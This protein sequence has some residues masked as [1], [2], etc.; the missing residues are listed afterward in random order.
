MIDVIGQTV[1]DYVL[2]EYLGAG[3]VGQVF[4][5]R[6]ITT[7]R[8]H[9][10]K[11]VHQQLADD[12]DFRAW[13]AGRWR[14]VAR[15]RSRQVIAVDEVA[16]HDAAGRCYVVMELLDTSAADLLDPAPKAARQSLIGWV[17]LIGQAG[18]ALAIAQAAGLAHG[19]LKPSNLRLEPVYTAQSDASGYRL[20]LSDFGFSGV[21]AIQQS[22]GASR[23][24]VSEALAYTLAPEH[25]RGDEPDARSD[26]YA[27]GA[28]MYHA[29]TGRPPFSA[30]TFEAALRQRVY[31][32]LTP[33]N[34]LQ[35]ALPAELSAALEAALKLE[36]AGRF[37]DAQA[38]AAALRRALVLPEERAPVVQAL[39]LKGYALASARLSGNGL[40]VGRQPSTEP[41]LQL[42]AAVLADIE[43]WIDWD[44][45]QVSVTGGSANSVAAL[46]GARLQ[47]GQVYPWDAEE[48]LRVGPYILQFAQPADLAVAQPLVLPQISHPGAS[49]PVPA[50]A[51][52]DERIVVSLPRTRL[53]LVP[54]QL[55]V[56]A[57]SLKNVGTLVDNLDITVEGIPDQWIEGT[58]ATVDLN[59]NDERLS[60]IR[61]RV[62]AIPKNHAREYP[63]VIRVR[64]RPLGES[65]TQPA[66]WH[67]Q[68]F[69][70]STLD[71]RP[72]RRR[73][74]RWASYIV[75]LRNLGNQEATYQLSG[76]DEENLLDC[77]LDLLRVDARPG[78]MVEVPLTTRPLHR[79]WFGAA[80]RHRFT[81][82]A[83]PRGPGEPRSVTGTF[84]QLPVFPQWLP[85]ALL[86]LLIVGLL[87]A[88]LFGFAPTRVAQL[89][90]GKPGFGVLP[91]PTPSPLPSPTLTLPTLVPP[92]APAVPTETPLPT[93][94]QTATPAPTAT[95][96][97]TAT[98]TPIPSATPVVLTDC[99]VRGVPYMIE[100]SGAEPG[101][102]LDLFFDQRR[103][104]GDNVPVDASGSYQ[105]PLLIG[106]EPPGLHIVSLVQGDHVLL[107]FTCQL[108][109]LLP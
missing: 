13:F 45:S 11:L 12:A 26:V 62:P 29:A 27:L 17:D 107:Q 39:D 28:I 61:V 69:A 102:K 99:P 37:G 49:A 108:R 35:P 67:V 93:N 40:A 36:P 88:Y 89:L 23:A 56:F 105:L 59:P 51:D 57:V 63:V 90:D 1:G 14:A 81:I 41:S 94:T 87:A 103:V 76:E 21:E 58:P 22:A 92:S 32:P 74:R 38:L 46:R 96:T 86:V 65:W 85:G 55:A 66:V 71:L 53:E 109:P 20:K 75:V 5:A 68:P 9:A 6:H 77:D 33:P 91:L 30:G 19:N 101:Q 50:P 7:G 4:R 79:L 31:E 3:P 104:G 24:R 82:N 83:L 95:A 78:Q 54:T 44:G 42:P 10:L 52:L 98:P 80:E 25:F 72:K 70:A 2:E 47:P 97:P 84:E 34:T 100:G 73:G 106:D 16:D 8:R 15:L 48:L 18:D 60:D 64:S 43:V